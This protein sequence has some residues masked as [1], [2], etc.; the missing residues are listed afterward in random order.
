MRDT[1]AMPHELEQIKLEK[2]WLQ[3]ASYLGR[4]Y[5]SVWISL[6]HLERQR[7]TL[8]A[9]SPKAAGDFF[10]HLV[11]EALGLLIVLETD[12]VLMGDQQ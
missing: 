5:R 7:S 12:S 2:Q 1:H 11:N 3:S 4:F 10:S 9:D 6:H 8:F